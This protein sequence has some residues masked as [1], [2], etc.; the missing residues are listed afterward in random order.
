MEALMK[1]LA[2]TGPMLPGTLVTMKRPLKDGSRH[3]RKGAGVTHMLSY[4]LR[5]RNSTMYVRQEDYDC[6][7]AMVAN[8]NGARDIVGELGL[9]M[10][11]KCR[12][13]GVPEAFAVWN[14]LM[15][16]Q[17]LSQDRAAEARQ[18]RELHR[19]RDTWKSS[20]MA[21]ARVI[22]RQKV[23]IRDLSVSR[24]KWRRLA[25]AGRRQ[26]RA[27]AAGRG[28]PLAAADTTTKKKPKHPRT[29]EPSRGAAIR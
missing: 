28:R 15:A 19:S 5:G 16:T 20:A 18:M 11:A 1:R 12:E 8:Y 7:A 10:V 2:A 17:T 14:S 3:R 4:N 23:T 27:G 26:E 24:D 9:A 22:A 29:T 21:R 25:L 6:V 13:V